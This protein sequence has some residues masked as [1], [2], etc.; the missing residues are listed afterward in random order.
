MKPAPAATFVALADFRMITSGFVVT[1]VTLTDAESEL[2]FGFESFVAVTVP[3]LLTDGH[4]PLLVVTGIER[5]PR[6]PP[7]SVPMAQVTVWPFA[8][9]P[10]GRVPIVSEAGMVSVM[11]TSFAVTWTCS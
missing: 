9:H 4:D 8:E 11:T 7:A 5:S 3:V 6:R 1:H 10:A 2:S